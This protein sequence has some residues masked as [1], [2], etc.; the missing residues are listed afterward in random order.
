MINIFD[1]DVNGHRFALSGELL[2]KEKK[3]KSIQTS[4]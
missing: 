4:S 2:E 3:F 1:K